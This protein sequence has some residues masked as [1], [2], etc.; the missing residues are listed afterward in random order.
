MELKN[1]I[2]AK[3]VENGVIQIKTDNNDERGRKP[4]RKLVKNLIK[5]FANNGGK[6]EKNDAIYKL[7]DIGYTAE[8]I[9]LNLYLRWAVN[10][11]ILNI[12]DGR[13]IINNSVIKELYNI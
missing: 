1:R 2:D 9:T 12:V 3:L 7:R 4:S 11:G 8:S 10:W 6:L 13:Y 5:I